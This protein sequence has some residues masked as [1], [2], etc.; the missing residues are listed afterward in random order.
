LSAITIQAPVSS[1][2]S[3]N[4]VMNFW[5]QNAGISNPAN[6]CFAIRTSSADRLYVDAAGNVGI[7]VSTFGTSAAKVL[8]IGT[9]TE[10][11]TGPAGSVQFFTSTR[12]A[13]NT[14]PAI[15][16][17]G[18][19]VTNAAITNTTVTNKIAI[20]VNGTI[21]YLLATTSAA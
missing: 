10:P 20:K 9:G 17:E 21:Y 7:G 19:G 5:F 3:S 11:T 2:F 1:G 6:E 18:S 14:I 16:T 8:S 12:S 13:N 4:P 15:F